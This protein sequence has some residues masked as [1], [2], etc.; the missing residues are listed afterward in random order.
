MPTSQGRYSLL[1][2]SIAQVTPMSLPPAV[3]MPPPE[4]PYFNEI[5]TSFA[6]SDEQIDL[7]ISAGREQ[8]RNNPDFQRLLR[9]LE[10]G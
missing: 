8:L 10:S 3:N 6:L 4:Q 9:Q 5:P 1:S 2:M 7:L